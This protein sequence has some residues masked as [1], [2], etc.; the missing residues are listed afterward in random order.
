MAAVAW[1]NASQKISALTSFAANETFLLCD[2]RK[3]LV[4]VQ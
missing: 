4:T 2:G 1:T 3:G